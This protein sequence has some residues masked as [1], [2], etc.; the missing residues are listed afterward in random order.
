MGAIAAGTT[1]G[2]GGV[3][4]FGGGSRLGARLGSQSSVRSRMESSPQSSPSK[5][6]SES[7]WLGV[8]VL[9]TKS[10]RATTSPPT[11]RSPSKTP[12]W[13]A[14]RSLRVAAPTSRGRSR[15]L[16]RAVCMASAIALKPGRP[17]DSPRPT[18]ISPWVVMRSVT[19]SASSVCRR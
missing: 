10:A 7:C 12:W 4:G 15:W 8:A 17:R 9:T 11:S 19:P 2:S 14:L 18:K 5:I 13:A 6:I 3:T 16:A 1:V